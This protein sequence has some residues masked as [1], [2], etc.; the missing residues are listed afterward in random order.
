MK[1][2]VGDRVRFLRNGYYVVG[3]WQGVEGVLT[4]VEENFFRMK[5]D[6]GQVAPS[7]EAIGGKPELA[8]EFIHPPSVEEVEEARQNLTKILETLE[9]DEA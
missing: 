4:E 2:K 6:P 3:Q 8:L 9:R 1:F 7:P 5:P